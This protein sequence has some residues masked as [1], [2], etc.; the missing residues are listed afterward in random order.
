MV[1]VVL[2]ERGEVKFCAELG[3]A[4]VPEMMPELIPVALLTP[5]AVP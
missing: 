2:Y 4:V 5:E 3:D 1:D